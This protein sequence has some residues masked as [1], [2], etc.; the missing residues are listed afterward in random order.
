MARPN[1]SAPLQKIFYRGR[2]LL[3][4]MIDSLLTRG[5]AGASELLYAGYSARG[6]TAYLHADYVAARMPSS[7]K[8]VAMA[9]AMFTLNTP[10]FEGVRGRT[11]A[12]VSAHGHL[13][14]APVRE[15]S[16]IVSIARSCLHE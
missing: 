11:S 9:D 15:Y 3:D 1:A 6:L 16:V 13:H 12:F 10:D 14:G 8:T 5:L 7:V 2:R 4:A